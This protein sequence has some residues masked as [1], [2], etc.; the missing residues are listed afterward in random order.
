MRY[1][2]W[3]AAIAA[4]LA[5]QP[6]SAQ[7]QIGPS[8]EPALEQF[9]QSVARHWSA[10]DVTALLGLLPADNRVILDTGSGIETANER[11]AAAALRALFTESETVGARAVRVTLA[12][13]FP[14]RGF[15]ELSWTFRARGSRGEQSRSVYVATA[16]ED[17]GWRITELRLMP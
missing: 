12:S 9:V 11:H 6:V 15:G 3:I 7:A 8:G 2:S 10:A 16:W 4:L 13:T 1:T 17:D 14:A 5:L